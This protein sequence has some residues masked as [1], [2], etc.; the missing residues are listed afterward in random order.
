MLL[1]P[2]IRGTSIFATLPDNVIQSLG[3]SD[4]LSSSRTFQRRVGGPWLKTN[5]LFK[6]S[7]GNLKL[8]KR[9]NWKLE[10]VPTW[11]IGVFLPSSF[12]SSC[13][14]GYL[15]TWW[16]NCLIAYYLVA[17]LPDWLIAW[18]LYCFVALLLYCFT[19]LLLYRI[20]ARLLDW[21][22]AWL[23]YCFIAW[24]LYR[25]IAWLLNCLIAWL[26]AWLIAWLLDCVIA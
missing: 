11:N 7:G 10:N 12:C 21:S 19:A 3:L 4:R 9:L 18:P 5:E 22:I 24:L 13:L 2:R 15:I 16:L 6:S 26:L 25:L 23:P 20:I 8:G 17:W 1:Q 14:P